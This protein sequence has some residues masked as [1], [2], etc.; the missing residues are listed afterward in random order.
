M[1]ITEHGEHSSLLG[2][3]TLLSMVSRSAPDAQ[4]PE[5]YVRYSLLRSLGTRLSPSSSPNK[6]LTCVACSLLYNR[7]L[8]SNRKY[9]FK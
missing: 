6:F 2:V 7:F 3:L 1:L 9:F 8:A 4:C 5:Q